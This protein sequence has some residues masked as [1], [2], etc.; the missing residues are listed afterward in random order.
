MSQVTVILEE[1]MDKEYKDDLKIKET[2]YSIKEGFVSDEGVNPTRLWIRI[3]RTSFSQLHLEL[4]L[5]TYSRVFDEWR[6]FQKVQKVRSSP[7]KGDRLLSN[8]VSPLNP[9]SKNP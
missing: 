7:T 5:F 4:F 3:N 6:S 8:L 2:V 9:S 1:D